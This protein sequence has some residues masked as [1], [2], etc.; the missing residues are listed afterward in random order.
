MKQALVRSQIGVG[1]AVTAESQ[2]LLDRTE[3][4]YV[5]TIVG[6]PARY[7]RDVSGIKAATFLKRKNKPPIAVG[8]MG[9]QQAASS[10]QTPASLV[11]VF[12]F[13]K[14]DAITVED[15]DVEFVTSL[16]L[17][18]IKKKFN[19]NDMKFHGQLEL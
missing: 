10:P 5:V 8:D 6:L 14:T 16:G 12:G 18:D 15:K 17:T 3:P 13:P 1:G 19:L 11:V 9:V 7:A 2:Q 4:M